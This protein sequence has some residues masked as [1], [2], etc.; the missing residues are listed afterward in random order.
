MSYRATAIVLW[1][2]LRMR[3]VTRRSLI[4]SFGGRA[5]GI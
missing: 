5:W 3:L 1:I 2:L 4:R